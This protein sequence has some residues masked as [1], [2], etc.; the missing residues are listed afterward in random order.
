MLVIC[1]FG[2]ER[3]KSWRVAPPPRVGKYI[4]YLWLFITLLFLLFLL[5]LLLLFSKMTTSTTLTTFDFEED[6]TTDNA[7]VIM[8]LLLSWET[9]IV[10]DVVWCSLF[11]GQR[12]LANFCGSVAVLIVSMIIIITVTFITAWFIVVLCF[13][14][15]IAIIIRIYVVLF[16]LE[17]SLVFLLLLSYFSLFVSLS[18]SLFISL[19]TA[20]DGCVIFIYFALAFAWGTIS[21]V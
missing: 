1:V 3:V 8:L 4:G 10:R 15:I 2:N 13:L 5:L 9:M 6:A 16:L 17:A 14:M 11:V 12:Q 21:V 20:V 19:F 18:F 7:G